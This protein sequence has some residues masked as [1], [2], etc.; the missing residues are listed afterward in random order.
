MAG[1]LAEGTGFQ[2]NGSSGSVS[3]SRRL[4]DKEIALLGVDYFIA[5]LQA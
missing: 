2:L 1:P 4:C 5:W 3:W